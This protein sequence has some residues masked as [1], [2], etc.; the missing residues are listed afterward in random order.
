MDIMHPSACLAVNAITVYSYDFLF[1]CTA[2][3]QT[4][5]SMTAVTLSFYRSVDV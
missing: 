4:A 5:H 1:N 3:C 2:V